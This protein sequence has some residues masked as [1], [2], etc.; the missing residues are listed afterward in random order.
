VVICFDTNVI[1]DALLRREPHDEHAIRLMQAL[2]DGELTG[3]LGAT[4]VTTAYYFVQKRYGRDEAFRDV[5]NLLRLFEVAPVQRRV[6]GTAVESTFADF[7]DA[8]LHE[9][10]RGA[11]GDGIVT[12]NESDFTEASLSI[13]TPE[14]L[15]VV[16]GLKE[17]G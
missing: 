7:E 4:S 13:Y 2:E 11:G 8:V 17:N 5:Q 10:A 15:L 1:L 3:L 9:A 14:E 16:L 6:L 12:R